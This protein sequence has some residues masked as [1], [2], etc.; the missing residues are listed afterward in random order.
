MIIAKLYITFLFF[1]FKFFHQFRN[2]NT[3]GNF[4]I[5]I[6]TW[7]L[8]LFCMFLFFIGSILH[9]CYKAIYNIYIYWCSII[10][11]YDRC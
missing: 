11:N 6:Q 7:C 1:I 5:I 10:I 4:E 3:I 9:D 2:K 8:V